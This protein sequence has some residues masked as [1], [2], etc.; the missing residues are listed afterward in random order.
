MRRSSRALGVAVLAAGLLTLPAAPAATAA[1]FHTTQSAPN[2]ALR[3]ASLTAVASHQRVAV[4]SKTTATSSTVA[5]PDGTFTTTSNAQ[6]VRLYRNGSWVPLDAGLHRTADGHYQPAATTSPVLVSGGG[7][8]PL[9]TLTD[10]TGDKLSFSMPFTLPTPTVSGPTATFHD[11]LPGVDLALTTTQQGGFSEVL[12][13]RTAAAAA[14]PALRALRLRTTSTGL[15]L[16]ADV[17]GSLVATRR[18]GA[19]AFT[20]PAPTMWDSTTTSATHPS[21]V[22]GP[23]AGAHTAGIGLRVDAG[24]VLLTP[25]QALLSARSSAFPIYLDPVVNPASSGTENYT[26]LQQGCPSYNNYDVAQTNGEGIGYQNSGDP[27]GGLYRS[28]YEINTGNLNSS[29]TVYSATLLLVETYGSDHTC[30]DTWPVTLDWTDGISSS[31]RWNT[32]P[33]IQHNLYTQN[34]KTAWCGSQDVS[35][36]VTGAMGTT[37]AHNYTQWTFGLVGD[38]D[39]L[40]QSQC[41]PSSQYNCGFM[42]FAVNPSVTTVFDIAPDKPSDTT[43][44]PAAQLNG[45]VDNGCG[46][47]SYGWIGATTTVDNGASSDVRL[48]AKLESNIVGENVRGEYTM[49]DNMASNNPVGSNVVS[50]PVSAYVATGTTVNPYVGVVLKDGHQYGWRIN[51]YD[52]HLYSGDAPDCHFNVD[53]TPPTEAAVS[54]TQFPPSGSATPSPVVYAGQAGTFTFTATDPNPAATCAAKCLGPSG[55]AHFE[56]SLNS[57]LPC[58]AT[59]SPNTCGTVTPSSTTTTSTGT[60]ATDSVSLT[61]AQWGTNILY[62]EAVDAAGNVSTERQYEFYAPWNPSSK[63]SPGDING[64]GVP[65]L[66]GTNS[67]GNLLLYPGDTDPSTTPVTASIPADSP[68]ATGWNTF[69]I[70]HR[71][72]MSGQAVDDLF[73]HKG[74]NVYLYINN[75]S[76]TS[77]Q[78]TNPTNNATPLGKPSCAA[79]ADNAG[80]CTGYDNANWSEVT[81]LLAPG[82]VYSGVTGDHGL[83]DLLTVESGDLWLYHGEYGNT[84][85]APV[86]LGTGWENM[87][88]VAPGTVGGVPT[89]WARDTG[90]DTGTGDLYSYSLAP[91]ANGLPTY[92]GAPT[93]GTRIGSAGEFSTGTYPL[94]ASSGDLTASGYPGLYAESPAGELYYYAGQS[95]SG[96]AAPLATT[97]KLDGAIAGSP[98]QLS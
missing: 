73:A 25:D 9:V 3:Q 39:L 50:S 68:D 69:Q 62:V 44:T 23:G 83:P 15:T 48:D 11:V 36:T 53:T 31:T 47:G 38:E 70:T 75:S 77:M 86:L 45:A 97:S 58:N 59:T 43:T 65:D 2:A 14:D 20:A 41:S 10:T 82:D 16:H 26:E 40:G 91:D 34:V 94:L 84:L 4:P 52:S 21:T 54:S 92:L 7:I 22:D 13:V 98:T 12:I 55:V 8:G 24:G 19:L 6:P 67:A 27:C 35:F 89:L 66:L 1:P 81:S 32:M 51:A 87:T 17:A 28:Y 64:G 30:A 61:P 96:G 29:M 78:F 93:S 57:P 18:G 80:N 95:T 85:S 88:L 46:S 74:T 49:W 72:S 60:Q 5:D 63:V 90:T 33:G 56:Y 42:R 79:T 76:T 71:G 37:A